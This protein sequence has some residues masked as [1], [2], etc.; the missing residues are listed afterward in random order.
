MPYELGDEW[1]VHFHVPLHA[2]PAE[3]FGDT[4]DHLLDALDWLA[5]HPQS[6]SHLEMETYTWEVLPEALRSG[7]VV[8]QLSAEYAWTLQ[9]LQER[10]LR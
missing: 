10:D 8:D 2:E 6:C 9:A 5:D 4:K 3:G 1:R 7:D